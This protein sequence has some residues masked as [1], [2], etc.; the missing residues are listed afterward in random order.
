MATRKRTTH[1]NKNGTIVAPSLSP[2]TR[3]TPKQLKE[4]IANEICYNCDTKYIKGH[5]C[6]E[7][8][9]IY[10][11]GEE[12]QEMSKEEDI[13]Q[14]PIPEK[15]E[16]NPNGEKVVEETH[17]EKKINVNHDFIKSNVGLKTHHILKINMRNFDGKDP[18]TWILQ[19]EQY[20]DLHDV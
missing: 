1:N 8:K 3:L 9:L 15:E 16:M 7:K 2:P 17:D 13:H 11:D 10:I 20:F 4:K 12:E 18:I 5:K 19:M 14:E 6:V